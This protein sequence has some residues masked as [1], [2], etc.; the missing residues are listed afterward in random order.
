M[1]CQYARFLRR[2]NSLFQPFYRFLCNSVPELRKKRG[3]QAFSLSFRCSYSE[4]SSPTTKAGLICYLWRQKRKEPPFQEALISKHLFK[5]GLLT[6]SCY[7]GSSPCVTRSLTYHACV[8]TPTFKLCQHFFKTFLIYF[9][10]FHY[11]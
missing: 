4:I 9:S 7:A 2:Q 11:I 5:G 3:N 8:V 1:V 6:R 10:L